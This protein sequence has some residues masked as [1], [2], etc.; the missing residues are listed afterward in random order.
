VRLIVQKSVKDATNEYDRRQTAFAIP[1]GG[2]MKALS[3]RQPW[4]FS[5]LHGG[6]D[7]ENRNW[8]TR[9]RGLIAI[10]ASS[11][12]TAADLNDW[13]WFVD[14]RNLRGPWLEGKCVG[15]A[16]RGGI[17]GVAKITGCCIDSE[18]PWFVG[19][20]GFMLAN[21]RPVPFIP[22]RGQLGL[23]NLPVDIADNLLETL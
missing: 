11:I 8:P 23:F 20:F 6:K 1:A 4:A 17:V 16:H 13:K 14:E 2:G 22:L 15:D 10:H 7:I 3:I 18:S 12:M 19:E 21:P 9:H 5:I